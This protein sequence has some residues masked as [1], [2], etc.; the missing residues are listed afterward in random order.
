MEDVRAL[1][2]VVAA[3]DRDGGYRAARAAFDATVS[4]KAP[5]EGL[6]RV[7]VELAECAK[8]SALLSQVK[9]HLAEALQSQPKAVQVWL[10]ACRTFEE[11]GEPTECRR[12]LERGLGCCASS[13]QLALKLVRVL[14]R[15]GSCEAARALLGSMRRDPTE[16]SCKVLLEAAHFEV[17][18][19]SNEPV[20]RLLRCLLLRLPHQGPTYCETCRV[21]TILGHW[22]SAMSIAEQGVQT[23]LKYGPLWFILIRQAEKAYGPWAAKQYTDV[24]LRSVCRELH[25]KLH[26]E[27]AAAFSRDMNSLAAKE[28]CGS[29]SSAF[30][31]SI[32]AAAL[33]CPKHLRWKVWLLAARAELWDGSVDTCRKLL[34]RAKTDAPA[35]V[36]TAV[37]IER[38]RTEEYAGGLQEARAV[39]SDARTYE[40]H[41]WKVFL[42]HIFMEARQ[43]CLKAAKETALAALELHPA[44]GRLWSALIALEHSANGVAAA[45]TTFRRAVREVPKSGEVWCEGARVFLNP[46]GA[47]FSLAH[48]QKC[49]EFAV[50]LTPQYGDSFLESL[51]LRVCLDLHARMRADPIT[52][53]LLGPPSQPTSSP[54]ECDE[55]HRLG[56]A[57][58]VAERACLNAASDLR[59]GKMD[60]GLPADIAAAAAADAVRGTRSKMESGTSL[61]LGYGSRV[62]QLEMLC[63][64]ADPNYG[65]LWFWCRESPLSVPP[66]VLRRMR[67]EVARDLLAGGALWAYAWAIACGVFGLRADDRISHGQG[68]A[69]EEAAA[70]AA[71][72]G[73][74]RD[75]ARAG[76]GVGRLSAA[77]FAVGSLRLARCFAHGDGSLDKADRQRLIFGSDILCI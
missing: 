16:R 64:Y 68:S 27:A 8:R 45:M 69:A 48:A 35:R 37:C 39:L 77:D 23:C 29:S 74:M 58:L 24:A 71:E 75:P 4:D 76:S 21:E 30:R 15:L 17:R 57:A 11:L 20:R 5:S 42:E 33:S 67:A 12:L 60:A 73:A 2:E 44:T 61:G 10:E 28:P 65:F 18:A 19:G 38:A 72:G 54:S 55:G 49:L 1:S 46:L 62:A 66:E 40:G 32:C 22:Q 31:S 9:Y 3:A 47:H 50:H 36:Q 34:V 41:D 56:L 26:F 63:T 14:E 13:E 43:G 25:W 6:W 52:V 70:I 59:A 53:G 51:R 7:H